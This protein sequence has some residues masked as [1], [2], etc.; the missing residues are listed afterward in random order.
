ML[1]LGEEQMFSLVRN[2]SALEALVQPD[3][4]KWLKGL[5][6]PRQ[7][8]PETSDKYCNTNFK[9]GS[10]LWLQCAPADHPR[11]PMAPIGS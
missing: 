6:K 10:P 7:P 3:N 11:A 9:V 1:T 5:V 8:W 2:L 4:D